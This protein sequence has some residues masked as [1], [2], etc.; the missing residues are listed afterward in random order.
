M[1]NHKTTEKTIFLE[2]KKAVLDTLKDE[3]KSANDWER[4]IIEEA[5]ILLEGEGIK[6][7][8]DLNSLIQTSKEL[9]V[10]ALYCTAEELDNLVDNILE[11]KFDHN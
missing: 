8:E 1:T 7:M 6:N 11:E 9:A 5:I 3:L 2:K 10:D 4:T